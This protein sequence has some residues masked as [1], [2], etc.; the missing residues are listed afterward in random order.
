[1]LVPNRSNAIL[2]SAS[3][4][5]QPSPASGRLAGISSCL[6][7]L[8][9][10][11]FPKEFRIEERVC[12]SELYALLRKVVDGLDGGAHFPATDK[13]TDKENSAPPRDLDQFI[14]GMATGLW[15]LKKKIVDP[16]TDEPFEETRGVYRHFGYTWDVL[17]QA[18]VQIHDHTDLPYEAGMALK[19]IAF[20]PIPGFDSEKIIET[21]KPSIYYKGKLMQMGEVI[22]GTLEKP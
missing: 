15:R 21:I 8:R 18:E 20:Q 22:V 11:A 9:Q 14:A 2:V 7:A 5:D 17:V 19:V 10:L 3:A 16:K 13:E 12:P 6:A 4:N 1:M